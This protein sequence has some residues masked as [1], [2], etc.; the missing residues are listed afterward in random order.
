MAKDKQ[1]HVKITNG[2][3]ELTVPK[4]TL[5]SWMKHG[6]KKAKESSNG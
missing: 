3:R 2:D 6:W 1:S 4:S 5:D